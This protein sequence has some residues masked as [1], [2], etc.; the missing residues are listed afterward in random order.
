MQYNNK[1][2]RS[3]NYSKSNHS[4]SLTQKR[5][6]AYDYRSEYLKRNPGLFGCLWF[7]SQCGKPMIGRGHLQVDHI[8]PLHKGGI[9]RTFNTVAICPECNK[10]KSDTVDLRVAKGYTAKIIEV[11]LFTIQK[12]V[13]TMIFC[14]FSLLHVVAKMLTGTVTFLLAGKGFNGNSLILMI[15]VAAVLCMILFMWR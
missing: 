10:R 5:R 7:C 4:K 9:N 13:I 14:I 6:E 2:K 15:I 11:V 3:Y 8:L 1:H 12:I